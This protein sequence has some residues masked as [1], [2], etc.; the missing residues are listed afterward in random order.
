M[1]VLQPG[2]LGGEDHWRFGS[3]QRRGLSLHA[4]KDLDLSRHS[5]GPASSALGYNGRLATSPPVGRR[6]SSRSNR[7]PPKA[8]RN[9]EQSKA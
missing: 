7:S 6:R 4:L 5:R 9:A 8:P 3:D 1:L 2:W